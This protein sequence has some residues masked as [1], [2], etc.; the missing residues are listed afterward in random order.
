MKRSPSSKTEQIGKEFIVSS[1]SD[2]RTI[3]FYRNE[4]IATGLWPS[5]HVLVNKYFDDRYKIL[6]IGCGAGRV[7]KA[8]YDLGFTNVSGIDIS[9]AMISAARKMCQVNKLSIPFEL[10]DVCHLDFPAQSFDGAVF[11]YNGFMHIPG[12]NERHRAL[13][14]IYRILNPG[15]HY[16]FTT[17]YRDD[18]HPFWQEQR[19][20]WL[21]GQHDNRLHEFGDVFVHDRTVRNGYLHIP[22]LPEIVELINLSPFS[23]VEHGTGRDISGESAAGDRGGNCVFWVV[24]KSVNDR[25]I[26]SR[27]KRQI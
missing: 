22:T 16:I 27:S 26:S 13:R 5:E 21:G 7:A 20:L 12:I 19:R 8:L 17:E 6:D 24:R 11:A 23:L 9:P 3:S 18:R 10:A 25:D 14:E 1:F 2:R 15:G 4:T